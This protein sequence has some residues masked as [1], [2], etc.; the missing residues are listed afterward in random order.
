MTDNKFPPVTFEYIKSH[1]YKVHRVHGG[2][3]GPNAYGEIVLSLY[4]ERSPIPKKATHQ[5]SNQGVLD[6]NA[7]DLEIKNSVIR[8]VLFG[9][10]LHPGHARSLAQ[11]LN[12][13]ADS[14]EKKS[15]K[16]QGK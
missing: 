10:S 2:I 7:T 1:D 3:G 12:D 13:S 9:V 6:N 15:K 5:I 8:D 14:L 16:M 11:W 4:F